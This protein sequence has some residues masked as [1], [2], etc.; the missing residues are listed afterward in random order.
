MWGPVRMRTHTAVCKVLR[1]ALVAGGAAA[2]LE[3]PIPALAT[4]DE[5]GAVQ[6]V[7][8]DLCVHW[9]GSSAQLLIDVSMRS[10]HATRCGA[11][12]PRPGAAVA[13]GEGDT[14]R[15]YGPGV[16]PLVFE[17]AGRLGNASRA[18]VELLRSGSCTW[19]K[20]RWGG[21]QGL[22]G[23]QLRLHLEATVLR[24]EAGAILLALGCRARAVLG[25]AG[26]PASEPAAPRR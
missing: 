7:V 26:V 3:R 23:R 17:A 22:D 14:A 12:A 13:G 10:H 21:R 8:L 2:A 11:S 20:S 19:G 4:T 25:W 18:S 6:D 16:L 9:P 15:R 24:E 1:R 5:S